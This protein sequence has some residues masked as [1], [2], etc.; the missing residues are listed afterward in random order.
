MYILE[1]EYLLNE[2]FSIDLV[3]L[4]SSDIFSQFFFQKSPLEIQL[5]INYAFLSNSDSSLSHK[6][7]KLPH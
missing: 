6:I 7:D 5:L 3:G 2:Y 1:T 4:L